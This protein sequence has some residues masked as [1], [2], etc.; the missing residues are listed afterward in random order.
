MDQSWEYINR[1]QTHECGNRDW[2]RAIPRK[3]IHKWDFPCS[4]YSM[5]AY[6][7][8]DLWQPRNVI[9]PSAL[10]R[11]R[12]LVL[13]PYKNKNYWVLNIYGVQKWWPEIHYEKVWLYSGL[14]KDI[15]CLWRVFTAW[16]VHCLS[17]P[18]FLNF[19]GAQESI[20][21]NRFRQPIPTRFLAPIVQKVQ[22]SFLALQLIHLGNFQR[23][24]F[25]WRNEGKNGQLKYLVRSKLL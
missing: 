20:P 16:H 14:G 17:E 11:F 4:A 25:V 18:V 15:P 13:Q 8:L 1:S 6:L 19:Y 24:I 21:R 2:R 22:H 9:E 5:F 10:E 7:F 12:Q 23:L 3:G